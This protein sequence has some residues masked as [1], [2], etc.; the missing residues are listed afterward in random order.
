MNYDVIIIG[1]GPGG[2]YSAYELTKQN[3]QLKVGV[4]DAGAPVSFILSAVITTTRSTSHQS[5]LCFFLITILFIKN[6]RTVQVFSWR[7]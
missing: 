1:A 5:Q 2:I 4:F 6:W 3:P 7:G